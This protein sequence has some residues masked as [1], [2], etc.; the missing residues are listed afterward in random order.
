MISPGVCACGGGGGVYWEGSAARHT[1]AEQPLPPLS[2][3][4]DVV[5][6][7]VVTALE[8]L[9]LVPHPSAGAEADVLS[10]VRDA[11]ADVQGMSW[12]SG[13]PENNY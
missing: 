2:P 10:D 6:E 8:A 5:A 1:Q 9:G 12:P 4:T 3:N 7:N 11:L 13:R